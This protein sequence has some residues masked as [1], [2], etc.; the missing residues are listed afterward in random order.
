MSVDARKDPR[1]PDGPITLTR[2]TRAT[3]G[4]H[5]GYTVGANGSHACGLTEDEALGTIASWIYAGRMQ[6]TVTPD[7]DSEHVCWKDRM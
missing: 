4:K 6:F 1:H 7:D 5:A 3:T 2:D